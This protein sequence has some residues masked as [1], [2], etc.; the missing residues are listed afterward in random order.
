MHGVALSKPVP[1]LLYT[2]P[3][4][5]LFACQAIPFCRRF[6]VQPM[7]AAAERRAPGAIVC[8]CEKSL[9]IKIL[10]GKRV[11]NGGLLRE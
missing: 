9:T 11:Y 5:G 7:L 2:L 10:I 8:N 1:S 4:E 6:M 3:D